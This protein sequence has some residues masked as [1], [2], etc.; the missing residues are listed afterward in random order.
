MFAV[1]ATDNGTP[2]ETIGGVIAY[3]YVDGY[4]V[5]TSDDIQGFYVATKN[6]DLAVSQIVAGVSAI[7]SHN[8]G[9]EW[10]VGIARSMREKSR[11]SKTELKSQMVFACQDKQAA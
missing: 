4:H 10:K 9:G 5:F 2:P 7:L 6:P 3:R 8:L 11:H 1:K